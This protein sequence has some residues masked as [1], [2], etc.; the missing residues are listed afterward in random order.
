MA[1]GFPPP[2][3]TGL[4]QIT[5]LSRHGKMKHLTFYDVGRDNVVGIATRYKLDGLGTESR[6]GPDLQHPSRQALGP[7]QPPVQW[8]LGL[9]PGG[10]AAGA[11]R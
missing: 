2:G 4:A 1:N 10:L 8:V 9:F 7:T 3:I 6:W 11:S 5:V